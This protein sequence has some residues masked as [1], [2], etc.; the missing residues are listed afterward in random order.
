MGFYFIEIW[1]SILFFTYIIPGVPDLDSGSPFKLAPMT[2]LFKNILFTY[3]ERERKGGKKKEG[4]K[5]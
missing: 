2:F 4:E 3:F 5:H 1:V